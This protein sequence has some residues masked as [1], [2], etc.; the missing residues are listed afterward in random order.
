MWVAATSTWTANAVE[1]PPNPWGPTPSMFTASVVLQKAPRDS[2]RGRAPERAPIFAS[3]S[4]NGPAGLSGTFVKVK[5]MVGGTVGWSAGGRSDVTASASIGRHFQCNIYGYVAH[6]CVIGDFVTFG[7]R[8]C[9]N[10]NVRVEDGAYVGTGATIK[11]AWSQGRKHQK[12]HDRPDAHTLNAGDD[13]PV[14]HV[15]LQTVVTSL[16]AMQVHA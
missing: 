3:A 14:A 10:G 15:N 6:D 9:C 5:M 13:R 16:L 12:Y 2:P 1:S 8:V 11:Q 4:T 7:P